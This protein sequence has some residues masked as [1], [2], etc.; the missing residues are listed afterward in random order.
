MKPDIRNF[1][2]GV[3]LLALGVSAAI[4]SSQQYEMGDAARMGPGYFPALLG[5]VLA[6]IGLL[7]TLLSLKGVKHLLTPPPFAPRPLLAV[8]SA[9]ALFALLINRVGLIPTAVVIVVVTSTASNGFQ[10]RRSLVLAVSLSVIAWLIF[11]WG[12]Q[13]TLPA[14]AWAF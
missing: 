13:M 2:A 3:A 8:I 9:V 12:L 7:I 4:Y 10:W 11:S 5:W 14:F 1:I 6:F